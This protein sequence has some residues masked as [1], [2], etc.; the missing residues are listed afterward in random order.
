MTPLEG[1]LEAAKAGLKVFP[2]ARRTKVPPKGFTDWENRATS[3]PEQIKAWTEDYPMCN[4][5]LACGPSNIAVLDVDV[6]NNK[7][8]LESLRSLESRV[9]P[10][11]N[12][13]IILTP[14]GGRHYYFKGKVKSGTDKLGPGLDIKSAGGYVLLPG[15]VTKEGAYTIMEF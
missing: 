14:S 10:L 7:P 13:I 3:D 4:F 6:K 11:P 1:A 12:T 2:I 9:G 5:A 8:G 15:S